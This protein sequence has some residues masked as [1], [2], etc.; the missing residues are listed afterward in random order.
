MLNLKTVNNAFT[1]ASAWLGAARPVSHVATVTLLGTS[2]YAVH[3]G[4]ASILPPGLV[5]STTAAMIGMEWLQWTG[6]GRI[7][8]LDDAQEFNRSAVLKAQCAGIGGLQV[9]LYTLAVVNFAREA[10]ANWSGGWPLVGSIAIAALYAAL[11]FVAKWTS[12]DQIRAA[13]AG[14]GPTGGSR[15]ENMIFGSTPSPDFAPAESSAYTADVVNFE[16]RLRQRG[17]PL[18]GE[19]DPRIVASATRDAPERLKLFVKRERVRRQRASEKV[20]AAA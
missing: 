13:R 2:I 11:N 18:F 14:V 4:A 16:N 19:L 8:K 1:A 10:G 6:L 5:L 3:E 15:I 12:C 20:A 7:T 17:E 9:I